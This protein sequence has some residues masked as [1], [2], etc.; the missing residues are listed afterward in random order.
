MIKNVVFDFGDVF[1]NLDKEA[2]I[3]ELKRLGINEISHE[4]IEIAK[5][6]EIG[7][8]SSNEFVNKF[9][10]MFPKILESDFKNAWN[11]ILKDFPRHRFDFLRTLSESKKY[12][13]FLLSNTNA[14]HIAYIQK[15][16]GVQLFN[17][18]KSFF[19]QFYLSHEIHLRKPSSEIY[20]F[21]L[22]E[23]DLI[24]EETFFIDD[25]KENTIAALDQNM[26]VW[27]INPHHEDVVNMFQQK[28]F[29]S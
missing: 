25:T 5:Q 8:F 9:T 12:R 26:K 24:P 16:W 29:N 23:N 21:V 4:M 10:T 13:L 2:P 1:I 11:A 6:F 15:Q 19:E 18:F 22:S 28:V 7:A 20:E 27:N 14:I 17:E 3:K